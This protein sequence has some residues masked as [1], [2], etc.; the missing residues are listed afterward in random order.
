LA[1]K[2]PVN[3]KKAK[4]KE[5]ENVMKEVYDVLMKNKPWE[6]VPLS[7]G[8]ILIGCKWVYKTKYTSDVQVDLSY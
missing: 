4:C 2:D 7:R 6:L 1:A 5:R 3:D 8:K